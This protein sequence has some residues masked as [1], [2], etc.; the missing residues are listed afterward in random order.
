MVMS[1]G[2]S[3][4]ET[5]ATA[6]EENFP[7]FSSKKYSLFINF[8]SLSHSLKFFRWR[9][10]GPITGLLCFG[11]VFYCTFDMIQQKN[12][13][14]TQKHPGTIYTF[15]LKN[16]FMLQN[17]LLSNHL[18]KEKISLCLF[19]TW[20]FSKA[21]PSPAFAWSTLGYNLY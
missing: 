19:T 2:C 1:T 21:T 20:V 6:F 3:S 8:E 15:T 12:T 10:L 5:N 16:S 11:N 17:C 18:Q 9:A 14:K 13:N 4:A 7:V